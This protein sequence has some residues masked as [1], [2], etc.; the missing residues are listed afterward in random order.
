MY[1]YEHMSYRHQGKPETS[2]PLQLE[3][4]VIVSPLM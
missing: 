4:E 1:R 2:G 3:L